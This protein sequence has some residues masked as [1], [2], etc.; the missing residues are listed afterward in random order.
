MDLTY[1]W[2]CFAEKD[3]RGNHKTRKAY[4]LPKQQ[5]VQMHLFGLK[6]N[7]LFD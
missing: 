6:M 3:F 5:L 4:M 7:L 2:F 1:F